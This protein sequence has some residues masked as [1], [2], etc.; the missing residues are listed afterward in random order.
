[1]HWNFITYNN[2]K[3]KIQIFPKFNLQKYAQNPFMT[4]FNYMLHITVHVCCEQLLVKNKKKNIYSFSYFTL[5]VYVAYDY[6]YDK[7]YNVI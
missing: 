6:S 1:M 5:I 7:K 3:L 2:H 4:I